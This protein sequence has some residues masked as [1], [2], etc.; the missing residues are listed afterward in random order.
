MDKNGKLNFAILGAGHIAGKMARTLD[1]LRDEANPYAIAARDFDRAERLRAECNFK[2]A[3]GS[4]ADMLADPAVD[5]VYVATPNALHFGHCRMCLAAGKH[6]VCE[7]PF[8][9]TAADAAAL[10]ALAREKRLFMLEAVWTRFQPAVKII[11]NIIAS[12]E[13]GAPRFLQASFGL[14]ISHKERMASPALGGG[15]LFDLGLYP[16]N[17]AGMYFGLDFESATSCATLTPGGVDDH[18][19]VALKYR[20]GRLATLT[21]SMTAAMGT[22]GR[23]AGTLGYIDTPQL[24]RCETIS[25]CKIP[26]G[27]TRTIPCPFDFNGYEYEIRATTKAIA[28]GRL[29]CAEM[30]WSETL[31]LTGLMENLRREWGVK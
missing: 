25:V 17:Y 26:S 2:V 21:T 7:K 20:D 30:P 8:T 9:T 15:A 18:S 24:T 3:Y 19:V 10:F 31:A 5:V 11:R 4:Y 14:A 27:K 23:I 1:F 13:I 6:V 29:E 16:L 22:S 12:G 28:E